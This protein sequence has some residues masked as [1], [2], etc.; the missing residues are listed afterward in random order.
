MLNNRLLSS[1]QKTK[2]G[3]FTLVEL[4]VVIGII[5]ILAGVALGPITSG[6]KTAQHN[7]AMQNSRSIAL[8]CFQYSIDN[9]GTYPAGTTTTGGTSTSEAIAIQLLVG[10][11]CSDPT[12]FYEP[13]TGK[14]KY[15]GNTAAGAYTDFT[16]A[17]VAWDFSCVQGSGVVT[18]ATSS[19]SDL[20]PLVWCSG[21][22]ALVY[23]QGTALTLQAT[24]P[25]LYDGVAV[26]YKSNSAVFLKGNAQ[27]LV[28][29]FISPSF[30]D[31]T[32]YVDVAP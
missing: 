28:A 29:N 21:N 13:A 15:T 1:T 4:L 22:A 18:G 14:A 8:L 20:L 23:T 24:N 10:K 25:F 12:I 27:N 30:N 9:N 19:A 5:A 7:T 17:N 16:A 2:R 32:N 26:T 3:G 31:P 6:I 11:Y